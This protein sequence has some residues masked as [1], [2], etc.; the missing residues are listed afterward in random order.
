MSAEKPEHGICRLDLEASGTYGWQVRLQRNG[1]RF[2]RFFADVSW[3]GRLSA[4]TRAIQFRD[5][6]LS[7]LERQ[8]DGRA[9]RH[10]LPA[11]R[12]RSGVVG[13]ARV[14]SIGA[15]GDRYEFWQASWSPEPGVRRRI[16]FSILRHGDQEAFRLACDARAQGLTGDD[17]RPAHE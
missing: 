8:D 2:A 4:L 14:V 10:T 12:N 16:R 1:V 7:R 3:G 13:V 17:P 11:A 6:L 9:R 5:R 15:N